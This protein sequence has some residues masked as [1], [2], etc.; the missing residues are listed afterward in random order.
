[1]WPRGMISIFQT[2]F[3]GSSGWGQFIY[4]YFQTSAKTLKIYPIIIWCEMDL[5]YNIN[6]QIKSF[7]A[8]LISIRLK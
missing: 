8:V 6:M 4:M 1:M 3:D 7:I 5:S 2:L